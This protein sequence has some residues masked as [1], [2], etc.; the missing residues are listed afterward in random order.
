ME[1]RQ[2]VPA[3]RADLDSRARH[4]PG[5]PQAERKSLIAV[6]LIARG[7][8]KGVL[9]IYRQ[10]E[11]TV[12]TA[13]EFELAKLFG[14]AV[15]LALDNAEAKARL[16]HQAQTDP[17]TGLYNHRTFH[18]RLRSELTRASRERGS[19]ALMMLDLDDFRA[20]ARS[21]SRWS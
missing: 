12:F 17:L 14:D 18:E 5:R 4:D 2:A 8:A 11:D 21:R 3:N 1:H 13:Q 19:V 9:N 15:A 10:G 16:E 6:P 20:R 7:R